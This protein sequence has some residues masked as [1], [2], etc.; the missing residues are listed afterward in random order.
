M[1][2]LTK[3]RRRRGACLCCGRSDWTWATDNQGR[4]YIGCS[5]CRILSKQEIDA[6]LRAGATSS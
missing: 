6:I 4:R 3:D 1:N 2:S 5:H